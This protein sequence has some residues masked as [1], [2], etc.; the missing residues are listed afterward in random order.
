[1]ANQSRFVIQNDCAQPWVL[2]IEPEGVLFALNEGEEVLVIDEFTAA[3]VTVTLTNSDKGE[4]IVSI[5]PGDGT[6]RVEKDGV[7]VLE[8]VSAPILASATNGSP[9]EPAKPGSLA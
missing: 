7:D 2:N 9:S 8:L 1:M 6:V 4:P 5:W 3:P